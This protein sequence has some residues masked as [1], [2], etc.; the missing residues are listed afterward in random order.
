MK[1]LAL[2]AASA[3]AQDYSYDYPD[4]EDDRRFSDD[5]EWMATV[6]NPDKGWSNKSPR[7]RVV[8]L[9]CRV[10]Q[11]FEKFFANAPEHTRNNGIKNW[12]N[13][14]LKIEQKF[15]E[16]GGSP[17]TEEEIASTEDLCGWRGWLS[18]NNKVKETKKVTDHFFKWN[19][20]TVRETILNSGEQGC[21]KKGMR[22]VSTHSL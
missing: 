3:L 11:Y 20:I 13:L 16:C 10:N 5:P 4:Y 7:V 6:A 17:M 2:F 15:E 19:A 18:N 8:E 14:A 9:R 22:L 21:H 1:L 12:T